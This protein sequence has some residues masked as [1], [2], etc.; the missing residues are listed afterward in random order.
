MAYN[1][2][3]NHLRS[4]RLRSVDADK[5]DR[6]PFNIPA[7]QEMG[8]LE[9]AAPVTFL[10]G[11]NGSGKSTLL[12][13]VA[14]AA[15]MIAAGSEHTATD[16]SLDSVRELARELQLV[17]N[18]RTRQGFF[19]R[20]EDFFGY[21]K[22]IAQTRAE[23]E[24]DLRDVQEETRGRSKFAQGLASMPF[25]RE[26]QAMNEQYGRDIATYSHGESFIE[27]F[28]ARFVPNGFFVLDEPEAPLSP[29]RQLGF[30]SLLK[31]MVAQGGQFVIAT[32]SPIILAFPGAVILSCDEQ[33]IRPVA[34]DTL[35]HVTLTRD[36]L[37]NPEMY[38]RY[39]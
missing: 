30:L 3:V 22:R 2:G 4:I 18:K 36:F 26:L 14:V 33:P 27:F 7:L 25:A 11:E 16:R 29:V 13:A 10:V 23:L 9:L 12:E 19:L 6:F 5:R 28:Q 17:W 39:L 15:N 8:T 34:Y 24:R 37:N 1:E 35:E 38:L 32:H 21:V 31:Q 20:A